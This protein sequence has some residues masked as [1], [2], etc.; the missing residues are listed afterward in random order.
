MEEMPSVA[1][2]GRAHAAAA[3]VAAISACAS[4]RPAPSPAAPIAAVSAVA[5]A[6]TAFDTV[7]VPE[8]DPVQGTETTALASASAS[9]PADAPVEPVTIDVPKD[10]HVF[11]VFGDP[12]TDRVFVYFHGKCGD[13]LAFRAFARVTHPFGTFVSFVGDVKCDG[14]R[15]RWSDDTG[16]LDV[17]VSHALEAVEAARG[18]PL[19]KAH[20]V[21]IGYSSG[22]LRAEALATKYPER[23]PRV[24]LIAG[25]RVPR[26]GS[27]TKTS[28]ILFMGGQ[29]DI[30]MPLMEAADEYKKTGRPAEF[31]RIPGARHGD[32]G[33]K[34]EE[35]MEAALRWVTEDHT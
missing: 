31:I 27:L 5:A 4:P 3:L 33:P 16:L 9:P 35:T 32:Y 24:V 2:V 29:L 30:Y 22:A 15:A 25:P 21:A 11:V 34:A 6:P 1:Q 14:G 10:K 18:T 8:T 20:L 19:D 26:P 17:R 7:A 28:A 23:Y 13:P 12:S